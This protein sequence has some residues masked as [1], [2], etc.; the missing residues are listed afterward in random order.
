[1]KRPMAL[2]L[3]AALLFGGLFALAG[4]QTGGGKKENASTS[5]P[6]SWN[7]EEAAARIPVEPFQ[8]SDYLPKA[9]PDN[10]PEKVRNIKTYEVKDTIAATMLANAVWQKAYPLG[11]ERLQYEHSE[12][13]VHRDE[14]AK[15]WLII[16]IPTVTSIPEFG[17]CYVMFRDSGE[18]L[19]VWM[20]S[21][22]ATAP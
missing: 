5:E 1:M 21:A 11:S 8:A 19:G 14:A 12:I 16:G 13:T 6:T 10:L 18:V 15:I 17:N 20:D 3:C 9:N 22:P 4:C 2:L 7:R